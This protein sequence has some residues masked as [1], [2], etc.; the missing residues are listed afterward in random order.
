MRTSSPTWPALSRFHRTPRSHPLAGSPWSPPTARPRT[1]IRWPF[2][3]PPLDIGGYLAC[4]ERCRDQFPSLKIL[5]GLELGEP[6]WFKTQS[7]EVVATGSFDRVLGSLHSLRHDSQYWLV[8]TLLGEGSPRGIDEAEVMREYL[9]EILQMIQSDASFAVL[10]HLD[11]PVRAWPNGDFDPNVF[12]EEFRSVLRALARSGR[13]LEVNTRVPL[14]AQ[15]VRWWHEEGGDAV[16]FGSDAHRPGD[17]ARV[18]KECAA[19]VEAQGFLPGDDP[20]EF[21]HRHRY[22]SS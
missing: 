7:A 21:W 19:M 17:L 9:S 18:F 1:I 14:A 10:A 16:S 8:G 13:V 22:R 4:I 2:R 11:Y 20:S 6:H 15:I 5:S 3:A 12:E